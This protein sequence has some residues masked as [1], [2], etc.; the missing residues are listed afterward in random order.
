MRAKA[1]GSANRAG[2]LVAALV[3]VLMSVVM[4]GVA[5]HVIDDQENR[6]LR[7]R[8][9]EVRALLSSSIEE[10]TSSLQV[11]GILGSLQESEASRFFAV[12]AA[13]LLEGNGKGV[14]VAIPRGSGFAV[15]AA[16]GDSPPVDTRLSGDR[17][18]LLTRAR[19]TGAI[20]SALLADAQG[21]RLIL[22][23][24]TV[25]ARDA[26]AYHET[27]LRPGVPLPR[28][29]GS[30]FHELRIALYASTQVDPTR[31]ILS[32]EA[33]VPLPGEVK[34]VPFPVG[35]DQWLLAVGSRSPLVGPLT[36]S[37]PWILGAAGLLIASA[38]VAAI[39]TLSRRRGY[40]LKLVDERTRELDEAHAFLERLSI[41]APVV[42]RRFTLPDQKPSYVSPNV[43][44]LFG[45]TRHQAAQLPFGE[46][47]HPD[48][49]S[50]HESAYRLV[51]EGR[52]PRETVEYRTQVGN[53]HRWV[54]AAFVPQTEGANG[55][56]DGDGDIVAVISYALDIDDRKQAERA[57]SE[58]QQAADAANRAKSEFLSRMSHELRTPL[59][60]VLG[61]AQLLE[62]DLP[63]DHQES[64]QQIRRAGSHLLDLIN[65]VLDIA[66]IEAG[67]LSLSPEAVKLADLVTEAADLMRPIAAGRGVTI[68]SNTAECGS[69]GRAD[70]QRTKQVLLNLL[71]NAVKY[72]NR[73]GTVD[74]RCTQRDP[75]T[76]S[77]EV[78]D[79]GIGIPA[80]DLS[81]L[82]VPF[83][84][85]SAAH[86][87][88][89]GTGVGLALS[90]QLA[91]AMD[92]RIE[93]RSTVGTGSTFTLTLPS[94]AEPA[95]PPT[96]QPPSVQQQR[97]ES[98][99]LRTVLSVEDNLA[100]SQL[101]ERI[102]SRRPG[103]R[104]VHAGLGQLGLDLAAAQ[105]PDLILLDLHLPD[106][107]GVEVLRRLKA[108]PQTA[109]V[110]VAILSAD[111]TPGQVERLQSLGATAYLTK[112]IDIGSALDLLDTAA[113]DVAD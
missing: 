98:A 103:W 28:T 75:H 48:D 68:R 81:R 107:H 64:V 25:G 61:F 34:R 22:A 45:L 32:T 8:A 106:I 21:A 90:Q 19:A 89:E 101:L 83:E 10:I 62:L 46:L 77:I 26:V 67:Q 4:F 52:S 23:L 86:S 65:E 96:A 39:S 82:F 58:A 33:R 91:H 73:H 112:P 94:A 110:P 92:G 35:G 102:V 63:A 72:N 95:A 24:P 66:R 43:E 9:G 30:P 50:K 99:S 56:G 5:Q 17:A 78:Q 55:A 7:E 97:P 1:G 71:S 108:L 79:S 18:A 59:N 3:M 84:R 47:V 100:N 70:R 16:A 29:P 53:S 13:P 93:V 60:A 36:Q 15:I 74:I 51:A 111:A 76:V 12:S 80:D 85:L 54:S 40:A 11:L 6:L 31:L 88:I 41:A 38:S 2:V 109:D 14:G 49:R 44:R 113:A 42:V 20:A 57:Q 27:L 37:A 105:P 104:L 87:D 69:Y